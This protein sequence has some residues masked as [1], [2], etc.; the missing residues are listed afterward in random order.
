[1]GPQAE[2]IREVAALMEGV[3]L[4]DVK[5]ITTARIPL[6]KCTF[7]TDEMSIGVRAAT[8]PLPT[9][10]S[11]L[12]CACSC[13]RQHVHHCLAPYTHAKVSLPK[14]ENSLGA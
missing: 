13:T 1:M 8:T 11:V 9:Q 10:T 7:R 14:F 12:H 4:D 6:V 3:E 2:V 5:A